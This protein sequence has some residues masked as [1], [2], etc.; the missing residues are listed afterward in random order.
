MAE[1]ILVI[2]E[3]AAEGQVL[4]ASHTLEE[5]NGKVIDKLYDL[6]DSLDEKSEPDMVLAVTK[7]LSQLNASIRGNNIFTPQETPEERKA[8]E[9]ASVIKEMVQ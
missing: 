3:G 2:E 9:Q 4:G 5:L 7:G 8:R 1:E 6:A